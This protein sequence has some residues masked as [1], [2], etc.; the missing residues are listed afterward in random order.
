MPYHCDMADTSLKIKAWAPAD[1]PREKMISL[2][3]GSLTETELLAI[4]LGSGTRDTS[5]FELARQVLMRVDYDLTRLAGM[6]TD[7][8]MHV[9]GIGEARAISIVS[10]ME[11]GRRRLLHEA[12]KK[13]KITCSRDAYALLRSDLMDLS[14]EEF[15]ILLLNRN[16]QVI[17]KLKISRGGVSGTVVDPKIIFK[18]AL[19]HLSCAMIVAHNHPSGHLKPSKAD[20]AL[21]EKL[22]NGG[23]LMEIPVLDHL[24]VTNEGYLSFADENLM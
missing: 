20:L 11:L 12:M 9:R 17:R 13:P 21:T 5:A 4:L 1:R 2:G 14:H 7:E 23:R 22:R 16:H 24:I 18:Q 3:R 15:W 19:T 10:A 8:L 6:D